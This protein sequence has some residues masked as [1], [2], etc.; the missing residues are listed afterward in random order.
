MPWRAD[1]KK[2]P[3][4]AGKDQQE[5]DS[6]TAQKNKKAGA[7]QEPTWPLLASS[8]PMR[9]TI[10]STSCYHKTATLRGKICCTC[11]WLIFSEDI[12]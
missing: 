4:Q 7:L 5:C 8:V 11:H 3:Q 2:L 10:F 6:G 9:R 12:F 1:K